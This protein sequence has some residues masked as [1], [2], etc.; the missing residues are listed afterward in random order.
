MASREGDE[1]SYSRL[2]TEVSDRARRFAR[3]RLARSGHP[4][5]DGEDIVQEILVAVHTKRGTW[6]ASRPIAP[7]VDAIIRYKTIDAIR[8]IGRQATAREDIDAALPRLEAAAPVERSAHLQALDAH[9]D[10]LPSHERGVVA[11][12]GLEGLSAAKCAQRLR[13]SETAVRVAFHRG[14]ARIVRLANERVGAASAS[15]SAPR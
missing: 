15:R 2:L 8:R 14:I 4:L 10:A 9:L 3:S 11:A 1:A 13:I 7:W 12:L 5:D 6:D